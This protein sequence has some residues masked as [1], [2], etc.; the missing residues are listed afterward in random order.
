MS[1]YIIV[2]FLFCFLNI[3]NSQENSPQ[4]TKDHQY[5]ES[6]YF[7]KNSLYGLTINNNEAIKLI[8]LL[9]EEAYFENVSD[10]AE[11]YQLIS[12]N[13]I[14]TP[15]S[16]YELKTFIADQSPNPVVK[17]AILELGSYYYNAKRYNEA[18]ETYN[19]ID[20]DL[21]SDFEL[22]EKCFKKGYCHFVNKEFDYA[23]MELYKVRDERNIFF[24]PVNYYTGMAQYFKKDYEAAVTSFQRISGSSAYKPHLPYYIT[25]IFFVK[26][27]Y[28][29]LIAYGESILDQP[30]LKKENEIKLLM[31]QAHFQ[32]TEYSKALPYL[33]AYE[34]ESEELTAEEFYQLGFCQYV[35]KEYENAIDNFLEIS[36][37]ESELGQVSS[38]YLADCL[39]KTGD[40]TSARS[41]F[42]K[43]SQSDYNKGMQEEALFNYGK[44]S[45][46][47]GFDREAISTLTTFDSNSIYQEQSHE[48]INDVLSNSSDYKYITETIESLGKLNNKLKAT[49][50]NA[51]L[52]QGM[53]NIS[54]GLVQDAKEFLLKSLTY[55][56]DSSKKMQSLYWT[57]FI[58]QKEGE[59]ATSI[60]TLKNYIKE[61]DPKNDLPEESSTG[62]ARYMQGYNFIYTDDYASAEFQFK[63][64]VNGFGA[65][66]NVKS[67]AI[68]SV[69]IPDAYLRAAD[70]Q[71]KQRAY[72]DAKENYEMAIAK[73]HSESDY[74]TYQKAMVEGLLNKPYGKL[75]S[76]E[77]LR[78]NYPNSDYADDALL[79]LGDTYMI[80]G[81]V[82]PAK[83]NYVNLI[84]KYN[85]KSALINTAYI[86]MGLLSYNAGDNKKSLD[87]YKMVM[88]NKPTAS[89]SQEA[90][91]AIEEIMVR[92]DA[93][94]S[95]YL[96]YVESIPGMKFSSYEK[97]SISYSTA[98]IQ[99]KNANYDKAIQA[100]DNYL[101][102]YSKG[103]YQLDARYY[104]AESALITKNYNTAL[105]DYEFLVEQG[106]TNHY[107]SSVKKAALLSYNYL[108]NFGK[109]YKYFKVYSDIA[110]NENDAFEANK[111]AMQSAFRIG[112]EDALYTHADFIIKS[113]K[114]NTEE[115]ATAYYYQGKIAFAN[116]NFE[117]S[118]VA[119]K[120]MEKMINNNMAAEARY[121]IAEIN[122]REGNLAAAEEQCNYVNESSANYPFW[123]AKSLMLMADINIKNKSYLNA[124]AALEAIIE[125]F[126]ENPDIVA[127]ANTKLLRVKE[128]EKE[129]SRIKTND[130]SEILELDTSDNK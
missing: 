1:K 64:A 72:L 9:P 30:G 78:D 126:G 106:F 19:K 113:D 61:I 31:G 90:L 76:L 75:T 23:L 54:D 15:D 93:N 104:R 115:K 88:Q 127:E 36:S 69:I 108:Q 74:A 119:F 32:R 103:F 92:N 129:N 71:F 96:D 107:Y 40:L 11:V 12:S 79:A 14:L 29:E 4:V 48:I 87:Y 85:G 13:R 28:N 22:S 81:N 111:G 35:E 101:K 124:T 39:E 120:K 66:K 52:N 73:K 44:I 45:A 33:K 43:V 95:G 50:Q 2:A 117:K 17:D 70:C 41:A 121:L 97:D 102:V 58:Q 59:Y 67:N 100:F 7:F 34:E 80:L 62:M 56:P 65:E 20:E 128:L 84:S 8:T 10:E 18:I 82:E 112:K 42:K 37:L 91:T 49:Y 25:Q 110:N 116:D 68:K 6:K 16:E 89:E 94:A 5:M 26:K 83:L 47:M 38:Y 27:Q 118:K 55:T 57:A 86:K 123:I 99:Y 105:K 109:A 63:Q 46:Q 130:D 53:Q 98:E 125:N 3:A 21:L 114:A 60:N 24:Y 51:S 122:F 77:E